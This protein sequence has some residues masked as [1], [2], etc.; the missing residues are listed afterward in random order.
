ME[1]EE[2][3]VVLRT[4]MVN[5]SS[6]LKNYSYK[7]D[8]SRVEIVPVKFFQRPLGFFLSIFKLLK[9]IRNCEKDCQ[10]AIL[11]LPSTL[12]FLVWFKIIGKIQYATEIVSDS[13]DY[14]SVVHGYK[15][16]FY[17]L[18]HIMQV[19]ACKKS[20]GVSCVTKHYLQNRYYS[21]NPNA[22][23]SNY[24]SVELLPE[25][26]YKP[27]TYSKRSKFSIINVSNQVY[28]ESTKG[29]KV[30]IDILKEL[31]KDGFEVKLIFVGK[32]YFNGIDRIKQYASQNGVL[33][34]VIFTG[35]LKKDELRENLLAADLL[36][37]PTMVEGL[38]RVIIEAMAMGLP[39]VSTN[40]SGNPELIDSDF[41]FEYHD[42]YGMKKAIELLMCN[43]QI[44]ESQS[45]IN[46]ERSKEYLKDNLDCKRKTF[47]HDLRLFVEGTSNS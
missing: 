16:V 47:F 30:L 25:N 22:V 14:S 11:R 28:L 12:A 17:Y 8:S 31:N 5:D 42:V 34:D 37:L 10:L 4:K 1:F 39:C 13:K 6:E 23:T 20:I 24:S 44:Y 36:V 7:V 29:H 19:R 21:L 35:Y 46:Y 15:K 2:L 9:Q 32:D 33:N 43:P 45:A 41:L 38:P 18:W 40:V 26:M 27:R 3:K